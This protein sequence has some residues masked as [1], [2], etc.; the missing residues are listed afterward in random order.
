VTQ[1][2]LFLP[3]RHLNKLFPSESSPA[4]LPGV[5][6]PAVPR[7]RFGQAGAPTVCTSGKE[8]SLGPVVGLHQPH[9]PRFFGRALPV[10]LV[11]EVYYRSPVRKTP[12]LPPIPTDAVSAARALIKTGRFFFLSPVAR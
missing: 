1:R 8:A 10:L 3:A 2:F 9:R 4:E 6:P 7:S 11:I 5:T 12:K